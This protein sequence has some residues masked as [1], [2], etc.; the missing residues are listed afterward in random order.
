MVDPERVDDPRRE[1]S[2]EYEMDQASVGDAVYIFTHHYPRLANQALLDAR[3]LVTNL[4]G[5]DTVAQNN[6]RVDAIIETVALQFA[7]QQGSEP[8]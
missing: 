2:I 8:F 6:G 5:S 4:F 7:V 1:E 3:R